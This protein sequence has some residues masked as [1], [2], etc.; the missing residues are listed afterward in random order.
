PKDDDH[1]IITSDLDQVE[2]RMFAT[3][4]QDPNLIQLFL[5]ADATTAH[6]HVNRVM[7]A[8]AQAGIFNLIFA[9]AKD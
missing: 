4:S 7:S 8:C 2:F 3:L 1:V 5:R 9:S 6:R